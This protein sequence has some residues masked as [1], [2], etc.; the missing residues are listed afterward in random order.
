MDQTPF[1]EENSSKSKKISLS[2]KVRFIAGAVTGLIIA[3]AIVLIKSAP[4]VE[5]I[6]TFETFEET[7][8]TE[9]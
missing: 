3:G 5:E 8:S 9:V 7:P 4:P 6:E 1:L 2:R